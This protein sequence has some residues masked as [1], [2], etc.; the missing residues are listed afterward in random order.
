MNRSNTFYGI[1]YALII[2]PMVAAIAAV[3]EPLFAALAKN[4][5]RLWDRVL[6]TGAFISALL[7]ETAEDDIAYARASS[8]T[9]RQ[10]QRVSQR[11]AQPATFGLN[12][13]LANGN[14]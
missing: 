14:C 8:F 3:L 9:G 6:D 7:V 11:S 12:A 5:P 4:V 10:L 1:L 2:A 13:G